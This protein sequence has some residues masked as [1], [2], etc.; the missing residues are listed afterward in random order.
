MYN[1]YVKFDCV[2]QKREA[3]I[4]KMKDTGILADIRAE[5]GC[6]KYDYYLSDQD[7][8][9]ILLIEQWETAEH[10]KIHCNQPHMVKMREFKGDYVKTTTIVE[11]EVKE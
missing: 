2:P 7:P 8:N 10:Q 6:H 4:Q 3:F 5:D 11:Y 9:L 1:I